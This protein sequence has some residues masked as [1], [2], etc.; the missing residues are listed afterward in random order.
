MKDYPV[1]KITLLFICGILL[2]PLLG[3]SIILI[4]IAVLFL[5]VLLILYLPSFKRK[6]IVISIFLFL[7]IILLGS[8]RESIVN[9][10][11]YL[12]ENIYKLKNISVSG[13]ITKIEL[14]RENEVAFYLFA[15]SVKLANKPIGN[16]VNLVCKIRDEDKRKTDSIYNAVSPGNFIS[17]TGTYSKG[18]EIRNP[19]EFDYN[20]YLRGKGISGIITTYNVENIKILNSKKDFIQYEIFEIRKS[21]Y[22]SISEL[23]NKQTASLLKSLLLADRSDIEYGT[24]TEFVNSG[25]IHVLA[26]SGLHTGFII[27][28]LLIIL[29]RLN[30]YIRSFAA[31]A[32]LLLF[33]CITGLPVSV[34]RASVM[35]IVIIA[36]FILNRST[37][38]F[39]SSALAA[40]IILSVNPNE[41]HSAGFQL[42]FSAVLSIGIIFPLF[43]NIIKKFN[44]KSKFFKYL[45]LLFCV[46]LSVEIGTFPV[47]A[48]YFRKLSLIAPVTNLIVIPLIGLILLVAI[49]TLIISTVFPFIASV[50]A[51][52]NDLFTFILFKFIKFC[53]TLDY[54]FIW[55]RNF[56]LY[57]AIVFYLFLVIFIFFHSKFKSA[58]AKFAVLILVLMNFL[59]FSSLNNTGLFH[60]RELNLLM[61]DVGQGDSFLLQMPYGETV[62]IDAGPASNY[63]DAGE[64]VII[65]LMNYLGIE[66]ID[67]GFISHLDLDHYGGF[68]SLIHDKRIRKIF[69]PSLDSA[70]QNDKKF[71]KYLRENKIPYS[72]YR[73]EIIKLKKSRIYSMFNK[74]GNSCS[75]NERS[76]VIKIIFGKNSI[77]F[78][79]DAESD[80][81]ELLMSVYGSFLKSDILKVGHHGSSSGSSAKFMRTVA[82]EFSLIS[83]GIQN[84]FGHPSPNVLERLKLIK[85]KIYRTDEIGAVLFRCTGDSIYTVNWKNN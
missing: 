78:T 32:G 14:K 63:F 62:L 84:K 20:K 43:Q 60:N 3:I 74:L 76:G 19:G 9:K 51:A 11:S 30:I 65:P 67:Y 5:S 26:V 61:V 34:F 18:R 1:I 79:G 15:D 71:E 82:P 48:A 16:G 41:I 75:K 12:S 52:A 46:S 54:S 77:L 47:T 83:A 56:F 31:V 49:G 2:Q 39:N 38:I 6:D 29:G 81:E 44:F 53:G 36:A 25:V 50:Y 17:I 72:Y 59:L 69:K 80:R 21:I 42:S 40:F 4:S 73:K 10:S 70:D 22:K 64:Y 27:L 45:I 24:K 37:N 35:A 58:A 33:M 8:F 13:T 23:Q 7:L 28:F 66:K 68:V 85:S 57:D 55:I